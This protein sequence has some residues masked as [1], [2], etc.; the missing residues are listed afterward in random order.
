MNAFNGSPQRPQGLIKFTLS[1]DATEST[2]I[3][4]H[5]PAWFLLSLLLEQTYN[6]QNLKA[7]NSGTRVH[8]IIHLIYRRLER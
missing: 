6:L 5:F 7:S 1:L 3:L 8:C 2:A 4:E